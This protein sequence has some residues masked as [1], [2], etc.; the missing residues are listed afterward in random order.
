ML[1]LFLKY[2]KIISATT[3][4]LENIHKLQLACEAILKLF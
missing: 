2:F 3:N 4:I 1:K